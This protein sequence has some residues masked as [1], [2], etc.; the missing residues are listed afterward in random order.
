[1]P[2]DLFHLRFQGSSTNTGNLTLTLAPWG[3]RARTPGSR[4]SAEINQL[5]QVSCPAM[6]VN[7]DPVQQPRHSRRRSTACRWRWL[8][9][10]M[11]NSAMPPKLVRQMEDSGRFENVRLNYEPIRRNCR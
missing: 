11:P 4:S 2:F 3:E 5:M 7:V 6:R 10:I 8:V 9:T 1:V